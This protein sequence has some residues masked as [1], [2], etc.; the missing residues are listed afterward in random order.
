MEEKHY[1]MYKLKTLNNIKSYFILYKFPYKT[2]I[3]ALIKSVV[4]ENM[5]L[6]MTKYPFQKNEICKLF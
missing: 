5:L 1:C 4:Y 6:F 2:G 3:I